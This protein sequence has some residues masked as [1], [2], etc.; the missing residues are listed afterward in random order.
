MRYV[1]E[2]RAFDFSKDLFPIFV[3]RNDVYGCVVDGFW[4]DVGN[5]EGYKE[6]SRGILEKWGSKCADTAEM[7]YTEI[8]GG[9]CHW[10][11]WR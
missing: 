3:A 1:P 9:R 10:G 7:E 2:G 6:A 4:T 8:L 5:P 11:V